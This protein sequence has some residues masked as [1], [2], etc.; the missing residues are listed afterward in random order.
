[1]CGIAGRVNFVTGR[2]P[3]V[4]LVRAMCN[5][6][7]HRGP[8]SGGAVVQGI[9]G[10]GHRR[11]AIINLSP[12]GRQP[13]STCD[14]QVLIT[15]NGE[16]YNF[17]ELRS[18]LESRG[19]TFHTR[20]DTEVILAAYRE[21][22]VNCLQYLNGMFAFAIWDV[23][24][25]RLFMARDRA[26][27]KPL[28]YWLD[29]DGL[30]FAS[31]PKAFLADP[32]FTATPN[33]VALSA[34][35][36]YQYV[37]TPLSAFQGVKK[38]PPANYLLLERGDISIKR[39]W[40][41]S[42][43]RKT[44][45]SEQEAAAALLDKLRE[46]VKVRL[47]SDV[48]LGAFLSG[49]VDS[50]AI[51]ALMAQLGSAPVRTFSIGFEEKAFDELAYAR[52]VAERYQTDHREF[53]V[54]PKAI[55]LLPR[56]VWHYNEP[57][58]DSSA[59]P[60]FV[61]SELT[62]RYVT[63]ALNGDAGD[64]NFAGYERYLANL[65]AHQFDRMPEMVRRPIGR[66]AAR[67]P[68]SGK[69]GSLLSRGRRFAEAL[70][71]PRERRYARW[72]S[73]FSHSLKTELCRSDFLEAGG[74]DAASILVDAYAASDA[75]DFVD[76][77]LDV[78]VNNYLPD[79]LLVKVD[80]ATM[81]HGLE[82]RSPLLD[83]NV[84]EFAASLPSNFKI[85]NGIKKHILKKAVESLLPAEI[86]DRPKMG[87]GVPLEAWFRDELKEMAFDILL[88]RQM[89]EREYFNESFVKR[90]LDEHTKGV[91][92]WHYQLW[93]LLML[94]LWHRAFI[95]QRPTR[96]SDVASGLGAVAVT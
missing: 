6:L 26:G 14:G 12:A 4:E 83:H 3:S 69:S 94:E 34:Y 79:D 49:G 95:D 64:E 66:L 13:M 43:A 27:K 7:T 11:L 33:P 57:F 52:L 28:Y 25:E 45:I 87:F 86:I 68:R 70:S 51:V 96:F 90:L 24:R 20:T 93:N 82:G 18:T 59:I 46:A 48:P 73:H 8:D 36:T 56:L 44:T 5:L 63:V 10:L 40:K 80:I 54:R 67:M 75:T 30:A 47:I 32:A 31:E 2:P 89:R 17:Q 16:I 42:Y 21:F 72:M 41:L 9:A 81:A 38:V 29:Q 61:L 76:A 65:L 74:P 15:F 22:D 84:M 50:G 77:T 19:H 60:T 71:E 37:P 88:S 91:A 1:M 55:D 23:Q 92:S 35:L 53:V 78:D 62:R 85:K 58:A 39:Y